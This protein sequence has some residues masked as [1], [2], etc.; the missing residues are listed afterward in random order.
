MKQT[1]KAT[2]LPSPRPWAGTPQGLA[3]LGIITL[4]ALCGLALTASAEMVGITAVC[5]LLV[6]CLLCCLATL[7]TMCD[8]NLQVRTLGESLQLANDSELFSRAQRLTTAISQLAEI[9][10]PLFREI[11]LLK[12]DSR[13]REL[14]DLARGRIAFHGTETW[15]AAYRDLLESLSVKTYF[16][17]SWVRSEDYWNDPPG[18]QS[19]QLNYDLV[20]RG[21]RI[22]RVLI[23]A[24]E[25]WPFDE[26][27][28]RPSIRPWIQEQ[29]ERGISL[30][31]VRE[32]DLAEEP[33]LLG[34]FGIYGNRAVGEQQLDDHARTLRFLLSFGETHRRQALERWRRL[35]LFAVH[36]PDQLD[37]ISGGS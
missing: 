2:R 1:G 26:F 28:P 5:L 32:A 11:A 36:P 10:D 37:R 22:T 3:L 16:S 14:E 7:Q 13:C 29:Q 27:S 15:R 9:G 31:L 8:L 18:R 23:L 35:L 6:L 33:D 25:L 17:V 34:D 12:L 24:E 19:M 20:E 4:I 30:L 21:F